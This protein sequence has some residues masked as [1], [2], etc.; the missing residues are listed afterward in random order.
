MAGSRTNLATLIL[1]VVVLTLLGACL[2]TSVVLWLLGDWEKHDWGLRL[3]LKVMW[4]VWLSVLVA[5]VLTHITMIGWQFRR[6]RPSEWP[7]ALVRAVAQGAE[8]PSWFKSG[9]ASFTITVVL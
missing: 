2:G 1:I 7:A 4:G 9:A 3:S 6:P 5:T 8:P